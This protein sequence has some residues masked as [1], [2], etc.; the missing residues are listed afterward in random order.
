MMG[1]S[2]VSSEEAVVERVVKGQEQS[3]VAPTTEQGPLELLILYSLL[4]KGFE[5]EFRSLEGTASAAA[6]RPEKGR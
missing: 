2:I 4:P 3:A 5:E 1:G 6:T